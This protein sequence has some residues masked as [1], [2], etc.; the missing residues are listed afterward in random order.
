LRGRASLSAVHDHHDDGPLL[1][2]Y[3]IPGHR[4]QMI[5]GIAITAVISVVFFLPFTISGD[6]P[7][8]A[9]LGWCGLSGYHCYYLLTRSVYRL[10]LHERALRWRTSLRSGRIPLHSLR[11]IRPTR[12][13]GVAFEGTEGRAVHIPALGHFADFA[14]RV[15]AAAPH[16]NIRPR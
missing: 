14:T 15:Q 3:E 9:T 8:A 13:R 16:V 10:D 12:G 6:I 1:A 5:V 7:V 2:T 4:V 11:E